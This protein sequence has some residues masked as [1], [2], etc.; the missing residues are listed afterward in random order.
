MRPGTP[1]RAHGAHEVEARAATGDASVGELIGAVSRDLSTLM[2]QELELAKV[3]LRTEV[4]DAGRATATLGGAVVAGHM[5]LLFLSVAAWWGMAE[6]MA[7]GWAALLVAAVWAAI[8]IPLYLSARGRLRR[9]H[10]V[11]ERTV[12][13]LR[14][15]PDA[16]RER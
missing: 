2:R 6:V 7:A 4:A 14:N 12:Q 8:A 9:L 16:L 13:T 11:P 15:V 1:E 10:L 3:E 5:V